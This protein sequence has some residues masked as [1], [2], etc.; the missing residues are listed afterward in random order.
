MTAEPTIPDITGQG[1]S[2]KI[3]IS[4]AGAQQRATR[5]PGFHYSSKLGPEMRDVQLR[6][7]TT[8]DRTSGIARLYVGVAPQSTAERVLCHPLFG[9]RANSPLISTGIP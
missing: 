5:G 9:L 7:R 2:E 8:V 1:I 4:P 6:S 3:E